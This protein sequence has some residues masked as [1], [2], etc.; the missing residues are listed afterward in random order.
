MIIPGVPSRLRTILIVRISAILLIT[1]VLIGINLY[2]RA[3]RQVENITGRIVDGSV[4]LIDQRLDGMLEGA[5]GQASVMATV[6]TGWASSPQGELEEVSRPLVQVLKSNPAFSSASVALVRTGEMV[7]VQRQNDQTLAIQRS[8]RDGS[9]G[10]LRTDFAPFGSTVRQTNQERWSYDPR[11]EQFFSRA[12]SQDRTI[13]SDTYVIRSPDGLDGPGVTCASP[14]RTPQG[15]VIG[16]VSID[17]TLG[18]LS[19]F[20][21]TIQAGENGYAFLAER[22]QAGVRLV[23]HPDANRILITQGGQQRIATL[24]ELNDP[25]LSSLLEAMRSMNRESD[26]TVRVGGSTLGQRFLAGIRPVT[27]RSSPDWIVAVVVPESDYFSGLR[28]Q[29]LIILGIACIAL[30]GAIAGSIVLANKVTEPLQDLVTETERIR[31]LKLEPRDTPKTSI[32][33]I[34]ELAGSM[35][36]MKTG[37]RSLQKLVPAE[38]AR[39]L[40]QSGQEARLGG[41]RRHMTI[42]FADIIGFTTLS[43]TVPPEVLSRIL[44]EYLDVLSNEILATEGTID[45][46]NGD[47]VMAFW[48]APSHTSDHA[49]S[50]CRTALASRRTLASFHS[51]WESIGI[52]RLRVSWGVATGDVVV[53]NVGSRARMN[54]T[55]IGDTVNLASR[56]QGIN[57]AYGTEF[58]VSAATVREAGEQVV[59]RLVDWVIPLGKEQAV[60]IHELCDMVDNPDP[61]WAAVIR[62]Y[63]SGLEFYRERRWEEAE[64]EMLRVLDYRGADGPARTLLARMERFR[65]KP[66][67]PDWDGS[68]RIGTK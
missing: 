32:K 11:R 5:E 19:R 67:E 54:Y 2:V 28:E 45:K 48:G 64:A 44:S 60:E 24:G 51:E 13:W 47:D 46:F 22:S 43:E 55:V 16:V 58:L 14:I 42:S 9:G 15:E 23:A 4:Q 18:D 31:E 21:Q 39:W 8:L 37:L 12:Q 33:E 26:I 57:R 40:I 36:Q 53:G 17:F 62:H 63:H 65:V 29:A 6:L 25:V 10:F 66:P 41:E 20:L 59:T 35:E 68:W 38:Y 1:V 49:I 34:S 3:V 7:R 50:A 61:S 52:P 27:V 30:V 56:L